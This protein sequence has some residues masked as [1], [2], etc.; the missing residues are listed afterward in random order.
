L[1][2]LSTE[3]LS[4]GGPPSVSKLILGPALITLAVTLL[5]LAGELSHWSKTWF[6][7]APGGPGPL[8][9]VMIVLAPSFGVHFALRLARTGYGPERA[10]RAFGYALL[11]VGMFLLGFYVSFLA[12]AQFTGKL[13]LGYLMMAGG[14]ALQFPAWWRFSKTQLAYAYAARIPIAVIMLLALRG[15]WGTHFDNVQA[16]Y[17]QMSFWPAYLYFAL[18]PQL[19][20][21]VCY[22]V[23]SGSLLGTIAGAFV[24]PGP[25]RATS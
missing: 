13:G 1:V 15:R 8:K 6:D 10:G 14:A 5:H 21:W 7:P 23:V 22:T 16:R 3:K 11:G 9:F 19:V 4:A 24:D 2:E 25:R 20:L 12:E 18:L 17:A